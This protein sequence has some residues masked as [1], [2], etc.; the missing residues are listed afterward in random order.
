MLIGS[1]VLCPKLCIPEP[2][3]DI[4]AQVEQF[5]LTEARKKSR[6]V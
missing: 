6:L 4:S 3:P 5:A 1:L 2:E